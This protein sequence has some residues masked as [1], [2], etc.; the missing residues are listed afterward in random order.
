MN[1][2]Y[3]FKQ[4]ISDF[5]RYYGSYVIATVL[6]LVFAVSMV[7]I[8]IVSSSAPVVNEGNIQDDIP[9]VNDTPVETPVGS[10]ITYALPLVNPTI[11]MG[12]YDKEL[13]YNNSLKQWETHR[14]LDLVS[15]D[16]TNVMSIADGVVEK[17]YSNY[18]EGNVIVIAHD[19]GLR[20]SYASLDDNI[21]LSVGD[22]V[23]KG[24]VIATMS[25][26]AYSEL[27]SGAHLHFT[28][29]DNNEKVDPMAYLSLADK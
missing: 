28:L 26:S 6:L 7:V 4:K 27:N 13:V 9:S 19:N 23:S 8:A 5:F 14:S 11:A 17:V 15:S 12:Y 24:Q 20:S 3:V 22:S 10:V 29:Y 1:N 2:M 21:S 16:S 25:D 18:L